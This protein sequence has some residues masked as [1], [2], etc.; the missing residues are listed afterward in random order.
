MTLMRKV[1]HAKLIAVKGDRP[2]AAAVAKRIG[3]PAKLTD[4]C[5]VLM[6]LDDYAMGVPSIT[7][8]DDYLPDKVVSQL[9]MAGVK[10]IRDIMLLADAE[11]LRKDLGWLYAYSVVCSGCCVVVPLEF[12]HRTRMGESFFINETDFSSP[13]NH[14]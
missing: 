2:G 1:V 12:S 7:A 9:D 5:L 14:Q 4:I 6:A 8:G 3:S 11:E 10:Y 13:E